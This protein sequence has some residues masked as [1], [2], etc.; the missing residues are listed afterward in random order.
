MFFN[1]KI[2]RFVNGYDSR[3]HVDHSNL[4]AL[5]WLSIPDRV[6][7]FRMIHLFKIKHCLGPCYLRSNIVSVSDI[8]SHRTRGSVSNFHLSKSYS[9]CP[10]AFSY[11]CVKDWN[12]LPNRIKTIDSLP[13]FKRELR[14][15]LLSTYD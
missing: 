6:H 4:L 14:K 10:S 3:H 12:S 15:F 2:V 7:F 13:S 5:S 11:S 9:N 8:H 1:E